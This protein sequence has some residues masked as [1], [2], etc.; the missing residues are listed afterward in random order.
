MKTKLA[1]LMLFLGIGISSFADEVTS[2]VPS[3]GETGYLYNVGKGMYLASTANGYTL[4]ET[5]TMF[6]LAAVSGSSDTYQLTDGS[7]VVFSTSFNSPV[8]SSDKGDFD[9]VKF[10]LVGDG[11]YNLSCMEDDAFAYSQIYWSDV[12]GSIEKNQLLYSMDNGLWKLTDGS[13]AP[14]DPDPEPVVNRS[15]TYNLTNVTSSNTAATVEDGQS[16]TTTLTIAEGYEF[17]TVVVTMGEEDITSNVYSS[18]TIEIE[19]VTGNVVI[20][21][22][23]KEIETEPEILTEVTFSQNS[24]E[25]AVPENMDATVT[26]KL[27]YAAM[28]VGKRN[29]FCVPFKMTKTQIQ[30]TFGS[31][32]IVY[33]YSRS[34]GTRVYYTQVSTIEPGQT[35]FVQPSASKSGDYYVIN[36]VDASTFVDEPVN[37]TKGSFTLY[38]TFVKLEPAP[39]DIY[40]YNK[41]TFYHYSQADYI[42]GFRGY[43]KSSN[44]NVKITGEYVE[45]EETGITDLNY[46]ESLNQP[47][48]NTN[49]QMVR[50]NDDS[51]D[52][53]APGIYI[54]NG[55]K[56][57]IK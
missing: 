56:V 18:G 3:S 10:T 34:Y 53:L 38:G 5:G 19:T 48:Y 49:G 39:A 20:T 55:R 54:M 57:I 22:S 6:T 37:I 14:V 43:F 47:I 21:A 13:S 26:V 42:A 44:S 11:V 15:I 16:Y 31:R 45:D 46:T 52:G 36:N 24:Y 41:G 29:S 35:Y 7:A 27:D 50:T 1:M 30:E 40:T 25:F 17:E 33:A 32:T 12:T 8:C 28:T 23:A 51:V 4:S 9:E 2:K